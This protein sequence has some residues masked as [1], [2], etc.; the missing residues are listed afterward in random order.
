MHQ[1]LNS[2]ILFLLNE[3]DLSLRY[4]FLLS[5]LCIH[6]LHAYDDQEGIHPYNP[7]RDNIAI[8]EMITDNFKDVVSNSSYLFAKKEDK[9]KCI[10]EIIEDL[11]SCSD[12]TIVMR[13][14]NKT[15]GYL[16]YEFKDNSQYNPFKSHFDLPGLQA[17]GH[18]CQ[19]AVDKNY[20][21]KKYGKLLCLKA[22][23][24]FKTQGAAFAHVITTT[25]EICK[26]FYEPKLGFA[27]HRFNRKEDF[28]TTFHLRKYFK[29]TAS[30]QIITFVIN[31]LKKVK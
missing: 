22:L 12:K 25:E 27:L 15:I 26:K 11:A 6:L 8:T 2:Y 3:H 14:Q 29:P 20:R 31:A 5:F 13:Q 9:S 7:E 30:Q 4:Y 24:E 19:L 21:G 18:L 1:T 16:I 23:D 10:N 28:T 17:H